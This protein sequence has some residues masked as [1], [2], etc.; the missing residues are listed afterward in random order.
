MLF[1]NKQD[2]DFG[3]Q[4]ELLRYP[5]MNSRNEYSLPENVDIIGD[6]AFLNADNL[7]T[8]VFNKSLRT[9][10]SGAFNDCDLLDNVDI[11]SSVENIYAYAFYCCASLSKVTLRA[12]SP[13][14]YA[15]NI[16]WCSD[17]ALNIYVPKGS[18]NNYASWPYGGNIS[19]YELEEN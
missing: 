19:Y 6:A 15:N 17:S 11:P 9:V 13:S 2:E 5:V 12:E 10:E 8:V 16:F 3:L 1:Y 18:L 7:Q 14:N 4:V